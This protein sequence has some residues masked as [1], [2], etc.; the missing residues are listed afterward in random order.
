MAGFIMI[1]V[2]VFIFLFLGSSISWPECDKYLEDYQ[3]CN[4]VRF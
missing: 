2:F 1:E 4:L 3:V